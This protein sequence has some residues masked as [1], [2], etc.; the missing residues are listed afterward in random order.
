[1]RATSD[2]LLASHLTNVLVLG[3]T[4]YE[5]GTLEKFRASYDPTWGRLNAIAR[6]TVGNHEYETNN[7][8]S[9][10]QGVRPNSEVRNSETF[11]ILELTLHPR[12]YEWRFVPEQGAS[13]TDSGSAPC[14]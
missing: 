11:G 4:Q 9:F 3:D 1:M 10:S 7:V 13:F 14:H 6:P 5:D 8:T 2:L 12:S